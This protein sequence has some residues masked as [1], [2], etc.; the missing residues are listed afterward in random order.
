MLV[1]LIFYLFIYSIKKFAFVFLQ[2]LFCFSKFGN[3]PLFCFS[4]MKVSGYSGTVSW[5]I[6]ISSKA[7]CTESLFDE[8]I[9]DA[10]YE[11][12]RHFLHN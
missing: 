9:G 4:Y 12:L 10:L 6:C 3:D 1:K 7:L 8:L 11:Y 2:C 5:T